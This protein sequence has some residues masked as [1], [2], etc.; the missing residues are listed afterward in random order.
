MN[1]D[2]IFMAIG[3]FVGITIFLLILILLQKRINRKNSMRQGLARDYLFK[4]YFD[5]EPIKRP[6]SAK[7]FFNAFI[8]IETQVSIEPVVRKK[9]I[10]DI[11]KTRFC[12]KQYRNLNSLSKYK[13]KLAVFYLQ[14]L[15]IKRCE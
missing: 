6:V 3:V 7:F 9:I 4:R 12:K 15:R 10:E 1:K 14:S 13:R 2:I 8:D 11:S 5:N